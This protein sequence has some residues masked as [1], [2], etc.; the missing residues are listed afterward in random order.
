MKSFNIIILCLNLFV[1]GYAFAEEVENVSRANDSEST[2]SPEPEILIEDLVY[3]DVEDLNTTLAVRNEKGRYYLIVEVGH[4]PNRNHFVLRPADVGVN[5]VGQAKIVKENLAFGYQNKFTALLP[6]I[7]ASTPEEA[8]VNENIYSLPG[9]EN[10]TQQ[11]ID[12]TELLRQNANIGLLRDEEGV[13]YALKDV[14]SVSFLMGVKTDGQPKRF[15][16]PSIN[17]ED[18][19]D[20]ETLLIH[21]SKPVFEIPIRPY[22]SPIVEKLKLSPGVLARYLTPIF[23]SLSN[24]KDSSKLLNQIEAALQKLPIHILDHRITP[25]AQEILMSSSPDEAIEVLLNEQANTEQFKS[26][27]Q[28]KL[29]L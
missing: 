4:N 14:S 10:R 7:E 23:T 5:S 28:C 13:A 17:L 1:G 11:H 6:L 25:I 16:T 15:E 20:G 8:K 9:S 18:V 19:N 3:T 2:G 22:E 21:G 27:S 12:I 26:A 29:I 24:Q